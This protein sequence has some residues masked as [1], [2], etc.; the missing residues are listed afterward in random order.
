MT[1]TLRLCFGVLS[2]AFFLLVFL[3]A[4]GFTGGFGVPKG[5]DDG[6]AE[7]S[8]ASVGVDLALLTLFAMQHSVM[9]RPAFKRWFTRFVPSTIERSV[10]VLLAS[11]ALALLFWGW[12]PLPGVAWEAHGL[13]ADAL[14]AGFWLGWGIVLASTFMIS[15]FELFGL[16]QVFAG[17]TG[18]PMAQ[19][20]FRTP[21]LYR[22][23]RHPIYLGFIVAFWS[24]PVMT[25]GHLMFAAVCT[26]YILVGI[27][28]EERDL[29]A[30]FGKAYAD[31]RRRVSMLVPM[32]SLGSARRSDGPEVQGLGPAAPSTEG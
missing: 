2:Y 1:K 3:Y 25:T 24:A 16:R 12:R 13:T 26:A 17:W 30:Y 7:L 21:Y 22:W 20:A 4:V 10:F 14:R 31:Y 23:V 11:S 5:I 27:Q 9:A 6:P 18:R 15:H 8:V 19:A 29:L 28:L 32:P